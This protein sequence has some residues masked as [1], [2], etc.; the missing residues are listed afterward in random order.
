VRRDPDL[1]FSPATTPRVPWTAEWSAAGVIAVLEPIVGSAR[2]ARIRATLAERMMSVTVLLDRPHDPHNGAAVMRS[3]DAFGLQSV[4]VIPSEEEFLVSNLVAK[5]AGR[6]LD[7]TS[8]ASPGAA[9]AALRADRYEVITTHPKGELEPEQLAEIPRLALV[10]GNEHLGI[11][12]ELEQSAGRSVRI[13][14][15][16]FVESLNVS[17]SAGILLRAA[18][19][20]RPGDLSEAEHRLLYARG[21]FHSLQRSHQILASLPA[22]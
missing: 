1:V 12:A 4:H 3:C 14:M 11:C 9:I 2:Q 20:G 17:V 10:L 8:H 16:G 18:C 7:V 5:G 21:L 6:W 19:Q 15:R 22:R 13:P